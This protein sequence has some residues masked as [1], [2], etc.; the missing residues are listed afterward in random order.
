MFDKLVIV[1]YTEG[2]GGEFIS[3]FLSSHSEFLSTDLDIN[4]MQTIDG[5]L[6]KYLNSQSIVDS[7]WDQNFKNNLIEFTH[8][9]A[10]QTINAVAVPYHLYK[11]PHHIDAITHQQPN[12]RFVKINY[13]QSRQSDIFLDFFRKVW[14]R[15]L[16]KS[17]LSEIKF[18]T[19]GFATADKQ[20]VVQR[21]QTNKLYYLDLVLIKNGIA[22]TAKNRQMA[23]DEFQTQSP[24][25]CPSTDIAIEYDDFFVDFTRTP[26]AYKQ[27]CEQLKILPD[28]EKLDKLI[29][30]NKKNYL[31]LK[32]FATNFENLLKDL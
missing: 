26:D 2:A 27:L 5:T 29:E 4:D 25:L 22:A 7:N 8:L 11:W 15:K 9:C 17:N 18:I 19:D 6:L 16:N 32:K 20:T 28:I 24:R 10:G 3:Y 1:D 31:E 13:K 14:L 30:R 21:L 23:V 12:A